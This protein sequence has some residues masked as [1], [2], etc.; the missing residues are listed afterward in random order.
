MNDYGALIS[1]LCPDDKTKFRKLENVSKKLIKKKWSVV[2]NS[3]CLENCKII[4]FIRYKTLI[5]SK[6]NR[7]VSLRIIISKVNWLLKKIHETLLHLKIKKNF[8]S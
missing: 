4:K 5:I 7:L 1:Q 8:I 3:T 6:I 2:F